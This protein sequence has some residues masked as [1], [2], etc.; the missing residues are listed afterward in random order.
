[1][2]TTTQPIPAT[3]LKTGTS[4]VRLATGRLNLI[5]TIIVLLILILGALLYDYIWEGFSA[6]SSGYLLGSI[7]YQYFWETLLCALLANLL[8]SYLLL[9]FL[10]GRKAKD[11]GFIANWAGVAFYTKRRFLHQTPPAPE[12]L[13]ARPAAA[14]RLAGRVARRARLLHRPTGG[15]F[16]R[17]DE[18]GSGHRRPD[19]VVPPQLPPA[20]RLRP[21]DGDILV[22]GRGYLRPRTATS[23]STGAII[24]R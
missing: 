13:P 20:Q 19:A 21:A 3:T 6:Y 14:C 12:V 22:H 2:P 9:Y 1:M 7:L 8:L 11:I 17:A 5:A 4:E 15:L 23:A 16:L 24:R 18:P 10:N